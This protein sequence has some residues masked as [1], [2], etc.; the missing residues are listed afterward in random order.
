MYN[1]HLAHLSFFDFWGVGS[2]VQKGVQM[3]VGKTY[4]DLY[5]W[6]QNIFFLY[7]KC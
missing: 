1:Y 4:L 6:N 2:V 3:K 7:G 5:N